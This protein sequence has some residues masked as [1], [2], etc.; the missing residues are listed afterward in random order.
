[1]STLAGENDC[2]KE[3]LSLEPCLSQVAAA[4]ISGFK[5]THTRAFSALKTLQNK[6][7][8][9]DTSSPSPAHSGWF[10][11]TLWQ[12]HGVIVWPGFFGVCRETPG[13]TQVW[14]KSSTLNRDVVCGSVTENA[15]TLL[16][17]SKLCRHRN[18]KIE[19]GVEWDTGDIKASAGGP[20]STSLPEAGQTKDE[21]SPQ[22]CCFSPFP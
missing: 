8:Q 2:E 6:E 5:I 22:L 21:V 19:E 1:M 13:E 15:M 17:R 7:T 11:E 3:M 4:S 16:T 20:H 10:R 18:Y 9:I 12:P 14:S